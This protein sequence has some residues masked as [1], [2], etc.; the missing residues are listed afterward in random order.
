MSIGIIIEQIAK[1]ISLLASFFLIAGLLKIY[2]YYKF[3]GIYIFEF[4][5]AK[6]ALTLFVN[7]LLSYTFFLSTFCL[8]IFFSSVW[9]SA[10]QFILPVFLSAFSV[11]Y[12]FLRKKVHLYETVLHN[13]AIWILF[14]AAKTINTTSLSTLLKDAN[15]TSLIF[16]VTLCFYSIISAVSEFYKVKYK[17]Y[18]LNTIILIDEEQIISTKD[19]FY[20]GKT[21]KYLFLHNLKDKSNE[22]VP[23]NSIKKIVFKFN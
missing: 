16:V 18:Y 22:I 13:I 11:I 8:F 23:T 7:N 12:L 4:M 20:I 19:F 21:D 2:A 5:E 6:E 9:N 3:F 10:I 15:I 1:N 17:K 14:L